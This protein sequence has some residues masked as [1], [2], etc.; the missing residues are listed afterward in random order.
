MNLYIGI[1][2]IVDVQL[3]GR[4]LNFGLTVEQAKPC[5]VPCVLFDPTNEIKEQ[6]ADLQLTEQTVWLQGRLASYEFEYEGKKRRRID[7]I[8]YSGSIKP[9]N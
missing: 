2:K 1:G 5:Y 9:I 7:V 4:V 8:A 3:N 6:L